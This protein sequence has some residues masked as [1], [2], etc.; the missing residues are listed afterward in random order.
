MRTLSATLAAAG[1]ALIV[2][3]PEPARGQTVYERIDRYRVDPA[4]R[5]PYPDAYRPSPRRY[6]SWQRRPYDPP[7][8]GA[9]RSAYPG[10][11]GYFDWR[12]EARSRALMPYWQYGQG[13]YATPYGTYRPLPPFGAPPPWQRRYYGG[14]GDYGFG[15]WRPLHRAP[16]YDGR[17]I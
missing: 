11:R 5:Y 17:S 6:E 10:D 13:W 3:A 14:Y 12:S 15:G 16:A 4:P 2:I 8:N 7:R 9:G 1:L